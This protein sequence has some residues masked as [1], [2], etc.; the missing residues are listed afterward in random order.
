MTTD[1]CT[2]VENDGYW[3]SACD[4]SFIFNDCAR[5]S[6]HKFKFCPFCGKPIVEQPEVPNG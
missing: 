5:P 6:E 1:T 4:H 2:W 3:E